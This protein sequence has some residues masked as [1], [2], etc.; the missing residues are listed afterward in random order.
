ML[1]ALGLDHVGFAGSEVRRVT[2][3]RTL[4]VTLPL[5]GFPL[6]LISHYQSHR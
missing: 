2:G 4:G 6:L 5:L 1:A 3:R